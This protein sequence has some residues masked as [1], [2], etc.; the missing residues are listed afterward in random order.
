LQQQKPLHKKCKCGEKFC[1]PELED[2]VKRR[3]ITKTP[4]ALQQIKLL[5]ILNLKSAGEGVA[6]YQPSPSSERRSL[7]SCPLSQVSWYLG[8]NKVYQ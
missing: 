8:F 5:D 6:Y 4:L 7:L 1:Q 3:C 2:D